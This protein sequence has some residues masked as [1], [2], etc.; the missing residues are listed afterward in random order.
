MTAPL[1]SV[2]VPA[3][4]IDRYLTDAVESLLQQ[5][6][7]DLEIVVVL[8]GIPDVQLP[9]WSLDHRVVVERLPTHHGT[10]A[11]LNHGIVIGRGVYVARLDADDLAHADRLQAQVDF[12]ESHPEVVCL[13]SSALIMD[14]DGAV[15]G[16]LTSPTGPE[17]VRRSLLTR[18]TLTHSSVV[19]RR[20]A[21]ER[22]GGYNLK[23]RRMQDYELFLRMATIGGID[24][25][26]EPLVS[27]RVHPGQHSR[28]SSPWAPYTR[29]VLKRR[30]ELAG[31]V[32]ASKSGQVA[33][34][35]AWWMMQVAR[36][37]GLVRPGYL[38]RKAP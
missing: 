19:Y 12:L 24:N 13:G 6:M 17:N 16:R 8:D 33:R 1:V 38:R 21:L 30:R 22:T 28:A 18:N 3:I 14:P 36:H 35:A 9:D 5:T 25:L 15:L 31:S 32:G 11:A 34:D 29:E 4:R 23:C 20:S 27:Y 2:I 10:P 7:Q 26:P 37:Y